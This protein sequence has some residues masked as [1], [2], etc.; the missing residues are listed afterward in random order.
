[1]YILG[2]VILKITEVAQHFVLLLTT[3]HKSYV[4]ILAKNGWGKI[5]GDMLTK[6]SGHPGEATLNPT[7]HQSHIEFL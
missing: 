3:V 1:M 4:L 7:P 2:A 5:L 6:S